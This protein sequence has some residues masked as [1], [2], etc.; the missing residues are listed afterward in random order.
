MKKVLITLCAL[1]V[2]S[3]VALRA[4]TFKR[5]SQ[6]KM[7]AHHGVHGV[8]C[9]TKTCEKDDDKCTCTYM[10]SGCAPWEKVC[11]QEYPHH[12]KTKGVCKKVHEHGGK[13]HWTCEYKHA[14]E[15]RLPHFPKP[16]HDL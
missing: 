1:A 4:E 10:G 9:D 11:T 12:S 2:L 16:H 7:P 8:S 15:D 6:R 13:Y 14:R 3:A 5:D